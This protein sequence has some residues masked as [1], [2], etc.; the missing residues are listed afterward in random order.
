MCNS[1]DCVQLRKSSTLVTL[2]TLAYKKDRRL[3]LKER[4][5]SFKQMTGHFWAQCH[6]QE[7]R[8]SSKNMGYRGGGE[9]EFF[10][11][12]CSPFS[13]TENTHK[14]HIM[15]HSR[16][17]ILWFSAP[18]HFIST[19]LFLILSTKSVLFFFNYDRINQNK[20]HKGPFSINTCTYKVFV[21]GSLMRR[22]LM[23]SRI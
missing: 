23:G 2:T 14:I 10:L 1:G 8:E 20:F 11:T 16:Y 17:R 5:G 15:K 18:L 12:S 22:K 13:P 21:G 3:D 9:T 4:L 7:S 19:F 6:S